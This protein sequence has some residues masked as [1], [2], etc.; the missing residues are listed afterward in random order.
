M[1]KSNNEHKN[2]D[3]I[4]FHEPTKPQF[5]FIEKQIRKNKK[6][7]KLFINTKYAEALIIET[8]EIPNRL[9]LTK[10]KNKT[11]LEILVKKYGEVFKGLELERRIKENPEILEIYLKN[12]ITPINYKN[13][14][15]YLLKKINGITLLEYVLNNYDYHWKTDYANLESRI[16]TNKQI[17]DIVVNYFIK[18]E[19]LTKEQIRLLSCIIEY[20]TPDNRLN[21]YKKHWNVIK[22]DIERYILENIDGETINFLIGI[23]EYDILKKITDT[24][25]LNKKIDEHNTLFSFLI[26]KGIIKIENYYYKIEDLIKPIIEN[27]MYEALEKII[28]NKYYI[29]LKKYDDTNTLLELLINKKNVD[30]FSTDSWL[31]II[32]L[33]KNDIR[34]A[35]ILLKNDKWCSLLDTSDSILDSRYDENTTYYEILTSK[36][37]E[38]LNAG[39]YGY[40][41]FFSMSKRILL[42]KYDNK[43]ILEH[44]LQEG[45][46]LMVL[47]K[48]NQNELYNDAE[49]QTILKLNGINIE[50]EFGKN[51]ETTFDITKP[52]KIQKDDIIKKTYEPYL[53]ENLRYEQQE[54]LNELRNIFI[55]DGK[56]DTEVITLACDTF[57]YLF[58]NNYKYTERDLNSLINIKKNNPEFIMI[59]GYK[60]YFEHMGIITI[61]EIYN[62]NTFVHE[63]AHAI[64]W[65][66]TSNK[67]PELFKQ[68]QFEINEEKFNEFIEQFV[69]QRIEIFERLKQNNY[70]FYNENTSAKEEEKK[71]KQRIKEIL[72]NA[73]ENELCTPEI[74][75]YLKENIA[76]EEEYK[77]YY[78]KVAIEE[79]AI[80]YQKDYLFAI[81]DIINALKKGKIY[82][83]GIKINNSLINKIG[84]GSD[85]F[86][87]EQNIFSEIIAEY[88]EIIKSPYKEEALKILEEIVGKDLVNL[89]EQFNEELVVEP[90]EHKKQR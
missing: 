36:I 66:S 51:I 20:G 44:L 86:E 71:Y 54:L 85:Y 37:N 79:L 48:I 4:I 72:E 69:S 22:K 82:D 70:D 64:H 77:K 2:Q 55:E 1:Q 34:Y 13:T 18:Q 81:I 6:Y 16:K 53:K 89:L 27:Q 45:I 74:I 38:L 42:Y 78:N 61:R 65:Y 28:K 68:T 90:L 59:K 47:K 84:H 80:Q 43:T 7:A 60:S 73:E 76:T 87:T 49:I 33:A 75:N 5:N 40:L 83:E 12:N 17:N 35:K 9:Y 31:N 30:F 58:L 39:H 23:K 88:N 25:L 3:E 26:E 52:L 24:S 10:I 21:L 62:I 11:I 67:I 15:E 56:S 50:K 57:K 19:T 63:L 8:E 14:D 46:K 32:N 41:S 29:L